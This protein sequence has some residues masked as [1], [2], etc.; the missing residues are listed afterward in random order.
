MLLLDRRKRLEARRVVA[1]AQT[2]SRCTANCSLTEIAP[3]RVLS[4]NETGHLR[5]VEVTVT[6]PMSP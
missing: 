4:T 3:P 2:S 5:D 1:D 6:E